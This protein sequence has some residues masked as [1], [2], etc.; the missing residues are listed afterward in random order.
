MVAGGLSSKGVV[1]RRGS[2]VDSD[3][4]QKRNQQT[5]CMC[6][7]IPL[8]FHFTCIHHEKY[9]EMNGMIIYSNMMWIPPSVA[10]VHSTLFFQM[11]RSQCHEAKMA[12]TTGCPG[13]SQV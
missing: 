9:H 13:I 12:G 8:C 1:I 2:P 11:F 3:D 6:M 4:Q 10:G 5:K 7:Y